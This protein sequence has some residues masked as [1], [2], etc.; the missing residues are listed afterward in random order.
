[1]Q[2]QAYTHERGSTYSAETSSV[3]EEWIINCYNRKVLEN[4]FH[5]R[6]Q[7]RK[8]SGDVNRIR[9]TRISRQAAFGR[10]MIC[11]LTNRL[12]HV[13]CFVFEAANV[14]FAARSSSLKSLRPPI[15]WGADLTW[16]GRTKIQQNRFH[17]K[18]KSR[19]LNFQISHRDYGTVKLASVPFPGE[20]EGRAV[21]WPTYLTVALWA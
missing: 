10:L 17:V 15:G 11:P 4:G 2:T 3:W 6:L 5:S 18:V 8:S 9:V 1:M 13:S 16:S 20:A 12:W 7:S 14:H 19:S 21:W